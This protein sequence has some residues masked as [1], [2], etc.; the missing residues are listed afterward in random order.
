MIE[1]AATD[2][3]RS[4]FS[5]WQR[6]E[7]QKAEISEDLKE[8]F[9]EAKSVGFDG[10][11]LRAAFRLKAKQDEADPAEAEHQAIVET[12][13]DALNGSTRDA[14]LRTRENIEEFDAE[15]GE[16]LDRAA[17]AKRRTSEAMDDNK[18]FSAE[19]AAAGLI[20]E[21]AHAEN[22]Q[23]S[24]AIAKK[25]GAG[26]IATNPIAGSSNGRAA[27]FGSANA[28]STPAPASRLRP[29]CLHP[30]MCASGTRDHCW[31]CRKVMAQ[32]EVSA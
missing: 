6:L 28:G 19:L 9:S 21:K 1:N 32:S 5:R 3:I 18:V 20:S 25:F 26:V 23:L 24:D 4:F 8:L 13:L 11:A 12:Y 27:D 22:I 7:E 14:R 10:K 16:I 17:R 29:H 30:E 15:T 2:Q 31:S